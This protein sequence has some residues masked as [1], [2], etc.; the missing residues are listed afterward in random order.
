MPSKAGEIQSEGLLFATLATALVLFIAARMS[1]AIGEA[2][3]RSDRFL[4]KLDGVAPPT[5]VAE[6]PAP[7]AGFVIGVMGIVLG[8]IGLGGLAPFN[9]L[10]IAIGAGLLLVGLAMR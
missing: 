3:D 6:N 8:V 9:W 10:T 4:K 2:A 1:P 7:I 5:E